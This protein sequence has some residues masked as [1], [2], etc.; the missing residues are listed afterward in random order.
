MSLTDLE[1]VSYFSNGWNQLVSV[2]CPS[3]IGRWIKKNKIYFKQTAVNRFKLLNVKIVPNRRIHIWSVSPEEP[4]SSGDCLLY[5]MDCWRRVIDTE[6]HEQTDRLLPH[7]I[8]DLESGVATAVST[9][10]PVRRAQLKT[11]TQTSFDIVFTFQFKSV[12]SKTGC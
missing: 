8:A 10:V 4:I 11:L 9:A 1:S 3:E 2:R 6:K 5:V 7:E 12:S